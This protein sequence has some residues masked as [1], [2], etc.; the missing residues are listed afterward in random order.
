[1]T[2]FKFLSN[3]WEGFRCRSRSLWLKGCYGNAFSYGSHLRFRKDFV[4]QIGGG[5]SVSIGNNTFFNSGCSLNSLNSITVGNDCIFGENVKVYDH[6]HVF[7]LENVPY[8]KSGFTT[9]PISIGNDVW[10][11]ANVVICKGVSIGDGSVVGAGCVVRADVPA[12][13]ILL[14]DGSFTPIVRKAS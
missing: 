6:N 2:L 9:G 3:V 1:M 14:S 5:G 13:S 11:C 12:N 8:R 4:V 7:S 10:V